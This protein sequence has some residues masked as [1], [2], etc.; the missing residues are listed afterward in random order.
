MIDERPIEI[1]ES[2]EHRAS[3]GADERFR[4]VS[5]EARSAPRG[6]NH[7]QAA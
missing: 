7:Q 5:A 3:A 4:N 1:G 6:G 2:I